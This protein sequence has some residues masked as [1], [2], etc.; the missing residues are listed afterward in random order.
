MK[1]PDLKLNCSELKLTVEGSKKEKVSFQKALLDWL[2]R[3]GAGAEVLQPLQVVLKVCI[4][5]M[6]VCSHVS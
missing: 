3:Q 5:H 2:E 4:L 1:L 6:P